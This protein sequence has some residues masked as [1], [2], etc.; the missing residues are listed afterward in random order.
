MWN[1]VIA[2]AVIQFSPRWCF[3]PYMSIGV[4]IAF[5]VLRTVWRSG[6]RALGSS[7]RDLVVKPE[8]HSKGSAI[9]L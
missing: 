3:R 9:A 7:V 4:A 5:A 6:G 2:M 1:H 8:N